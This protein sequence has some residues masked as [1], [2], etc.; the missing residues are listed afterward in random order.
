MRLACLGEV[1]IELAT[2]DANTA[3]IGVAGDTYNTAVYLRRLIA[4][5]DVGVSYVTALGDDPMSDRIVSHMQS[6]RI[7]TCCVDRLAGRAPGLYAIET[8]ERGERSFSYWRDAAAARQL[9]QGQGRVDLAALEA[10]D[11]VYFSGISLAI[12]PP[13]TRLSFLNALEGFRARGGLV[14]FDSN[15]RP[16]LWESREV[17]QELTEAAWQLADIALPSI[18]DEMA[19]FGDVSELQAIER[20]RRYG[21]RAGAVKRGEL[22]PVALGPDSD[23]AAE[24]RF[25]V[26]RDV[27]DTTAAGDSF[28]AGWLAAFA[29]GQETPACLASGHALASQVVQKKGAIVDTSLAAH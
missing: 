16:R 5:D 26:V 1:M 20:L 14:A 22:G 6:H 23:G 29:T 2:L 24:Q 13:Q 7:D 3:Q 17:A 8:D 4:S 11:L 10:F 28:N 25:D 9:F 12:L 21:A 19:L 18:D 15:Y 27:V